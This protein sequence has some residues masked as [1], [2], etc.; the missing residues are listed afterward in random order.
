M[1]LKPMIEADQI[2][3]AFTLLLDYLSRFNLDWANFM[4]ES[5]ETKEEKV[6]LFK[7]IF[8]FTI[9]IWL[10]HELDT[11]PMDIVHG[12]GEFAPKKSKLLMTNYDGTQEWS[13][14]EFYV[15]H[16]ETLRLDKTGRE[17][18]CI[19]SMHLNYLGTIDASHAGRGG[20]PINFSAKKW[21]GES[22]RRLLSGYGEL[23][24]E[25]HNR[26]N[27]NEVHRTVVQAMYESDTPSNPGYLID[28]KKFPLGESQV[29]KMIRNIHLCEGF[30]LIRPPREDAE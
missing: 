26:A 6:E 19:S 12:L 1:R 28:R 16:V 13:K 4:L 22:E 9:R 15:G 2:D 23:A 10:P 11:T 18:S 30:E 29:D 7:E 17:F 24:D 8:D 3:E 14:N 20:Y 27:S 21:M 5:H 25:V